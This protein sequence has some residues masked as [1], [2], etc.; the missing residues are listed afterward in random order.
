MPQRTTMN[1]EIVMEA[2]KST[3]PVAVSAVAFF[4]GWDMDTIIGAATVF[5]IGLQAAYLIWKWR[6]ERAERR[7]RTAILKNGESKS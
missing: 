3:P 2:V 7:A 5:Y 6:H 4:H 1:P